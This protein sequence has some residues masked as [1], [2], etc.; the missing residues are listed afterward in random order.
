[1]A[2][3]AGQ[4][5]TRMATRRVSIEH[6]G[7]LSA[8]VVVEGRYSMTPVGGGGLGERRRYVF[9]AG[10]P[11]AI[12]RQ[13]VQWEGDLCGSQGNIACNGA[14]NAVR[15]ERV[16]DTLTPADAGTHQVIA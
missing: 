10:S 15:V 4:D 12:V 7:P 1:T 3:V 2:H 5:V 6:A 14:P 13:S 16:R 11:T 8:V 9:T